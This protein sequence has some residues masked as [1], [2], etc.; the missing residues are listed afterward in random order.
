M[1]MV[2]WDEQGRPGWVLPRGNPGNGP[3]PARLAGRMLNLN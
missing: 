3:R 1:G 2:N